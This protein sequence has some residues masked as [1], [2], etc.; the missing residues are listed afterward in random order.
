AFLAQRRCE[1]G[2]TAPAPRDEQQTVAMLCGRVLARYTKLD[3]A[4]VATA[5]GHEKAW[6]AALGA[7]TLLDTLSVETLTPILEGWEG[8]DYSAATINR[9][10]SFLRVG[11]RLLG[12]PMPLDCREP[13]KAEET[14]RNG[15]LSR[16]D[17]DRLYAAALAFDPDLAEFF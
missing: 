8:N 10:L 2:A 13:R 16:A 12:R 4:S 7:E 14:P 15:Y 5:R 1:T 3:Q 17:L 9:R 6:L 11:L